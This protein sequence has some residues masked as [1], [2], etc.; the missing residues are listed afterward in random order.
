MN[1]S[2]DEL[3]ELL[4][5]SSIGLSTMIEEHF[6]IGVVEFMVSSGLVAVPAFRLSKPGIKGAGVIPV[7]HASG[8]PLLDIV[9]PVNGEPTGPYPLCVSP[10]ID[11]LLTLSIRVSCK[12]DRGVFGVP[13]H[14]V[15]AAG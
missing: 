4:S 13:L 2:Y 9:T 15:V 8:G 6:G 14:C 11:W 1:A 3:L 10:V 7:V 5:I 12:N